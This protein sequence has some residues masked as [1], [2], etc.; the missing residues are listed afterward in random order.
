MT[1]VLAT[2]RL[3]EEGLREMKGACNRIIAEYATEY[4]SS[5]VGALVTLMKA[6]RLGSSVVKRVMTCSKELNEAK[7]WAASCCA[8]P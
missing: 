2:M 5:V 4:I 8:I 1:R 6:S 3:R 7:N